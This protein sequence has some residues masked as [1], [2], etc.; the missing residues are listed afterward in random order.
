[1]KYCWSEFGLKPKPV[2]ATAPRKLLQNYCSK[3]VFHVLFVICDILWL[4][5]E[6]LLSC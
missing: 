5:A 3:T 2:A 1:M 6:W 4:L